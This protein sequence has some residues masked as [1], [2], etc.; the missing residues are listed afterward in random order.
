VRAYACIEAC[1][2][3]LAAE[4][5]PEAMAAACR[6]GPA[7]AVLDVCLPAL[8]RGAVQTGAPVAVGRLRRRVHLDEPGTNGLA[9]AA[10]AASVVR[11]ADLD[12]AVTLFRE[13]GRDFHRLA[14]ADAWQVLKDAQ[15][16]QQG[17]RQLDVPLP[18]AYHH[19]GL[20]VARQQV[21]A[22]ALPVQRV[23]MVLLWDGWL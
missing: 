17:R 12:A 22:Q 11:A 15:Q 13:V 16:V 7:C 10:W 8:R 5:C 21:F 1:L 2:A 3:L 18:A 6:G 19:P 23:A 9:R 20:V 14:S 4:L